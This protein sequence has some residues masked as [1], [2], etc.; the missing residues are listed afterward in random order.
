MRQMNDDLLLRIAISWAVFMS[1]WIPTMISP[2]QYNKESKRVN[3]M[4]TGIFSSNDQD[5]VWE[6]LVNKDTY[7]QPRVT[8]YKLWFWIS[9]TLVL[10]MAI[11]I[12][13]RKISFEQPGLSPQPKNLE[14]MLLNFTLVV[15][16][17]ISMLGFNLYWKK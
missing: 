2:K 14:S 8:T 11:K 6:D 1:V 5:L 10:M 4:C 13:R 7:S 16:L 12:G 17:T 9:I 3:S 15:L